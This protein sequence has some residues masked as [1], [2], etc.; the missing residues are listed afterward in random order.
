MKRAFT[1]VEA[2]CVVL[3]LSCVAVGMLSLTE[4][5][6]NSMAIAQDVMT[7]HIAQR[8]FDIA[9]G[10]ML[11]ETKFTACIYKGDIVNN[12]FP[13][14]N[15]DDSQV[16][17][18]DIHALRVLRNELFESSADL[19]YAFNPPWAESS[20]NSIS[21]I[22]FVLF[23][24]APY[25]DGTGNNSENNSKLIVGKLSVYTETLNE[26]TK[27]ATVSLKTANDELIASY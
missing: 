2:I 21:P 16:A 12:A 11:V 22:T 15:T 7:S 14:I 19:I 4:T 3:L 9:L 23:R 17:I 25:Y 24:E 26:D 8:K 6:T 20:A 18:S 1:L 10:R 27:Y 5:F 13:R